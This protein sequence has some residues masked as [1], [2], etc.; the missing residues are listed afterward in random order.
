MRRRLSRHGIPSVQAYTYDYVQ[1]I[2]CSSLAFCSVCCGK[3]DIDSYV[4]GTAAQGRTCPQCNQ[5]VTDRVKAP[6]RYQP[7]DYEYVLHV[8]RIDDVLYW[9]LVDETGD[10]RPDHVFRITYPMIQN[11]FDMIEYQH[12]TRAEIAVDVESSFAF[13]QVYN[14]RVIRLLRV[15]HDVRHF[16]ETR[17]FPMP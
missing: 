3:E 12:K 9:T 16:Y 6:A 10:R 17:Y 11:G 8:K 13:W 5:P 14:R 1:L 4:N 2:S 7:C 15:D